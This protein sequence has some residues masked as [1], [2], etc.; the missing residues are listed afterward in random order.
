MLGQIAVGLAADHAAGD[1]LKEVEAAFGAE[2]GIG[3]VPVAKRAGA[4]ATAA[5]GIGPA[6]TADGGI[7]GEALTVAEAV[8]AVA[9]DIVDGAEEDALAA[10]G[11]GVQSMPAALAWTAIW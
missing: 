3:I 2:A 1:G 5:A 7:E 8:A 6:A 10:G 11:F 9:E 4:Q